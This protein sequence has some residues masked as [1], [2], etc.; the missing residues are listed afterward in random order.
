MSEPC[1]H[2]YGDA[3]KSFVAQTALLVAVTAE[4]DAALAA[5]GRA[6]FVADCLISTMSP[7]LC[8]DWE[9][10]SRAA[11]ERVRAA[12]EPTPTKPKGKP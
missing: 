5:L 3:I 6:A 2:E 10:A 11:S 9:L 4:R 7:E 1:V 8:G 12:L